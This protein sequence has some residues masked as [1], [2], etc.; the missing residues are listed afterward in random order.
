MINKPEDGVGPQAELD[1]TDPRP[2][3]STAVED[4]SKGSDDLLDTLLGGTS[5]ESDDEG[6]AM[7]PDQL[8]DALFPPSDDKDKYVPGTYG[9]DDRDL[10]CDSD[11]EDG[12]DGAVAEDE[13][14]VQ[15]PILELSDSETE[16]AVPAPPRPVSKPAAVKPEVKASAKPKAVNLYGMLVQFD[17]RD[18]VSTCVDHYCSLTGEKRESIKLCATPFPPE[19]SIT[20]DAYST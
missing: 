7:S 1:T 11:L 10:F 14:W 9:P 15:M 18:Y 20:A 8:V 5:V 19:G 4:V 17:M 2:D 3:P 13:C 16:D 6:K 12:D